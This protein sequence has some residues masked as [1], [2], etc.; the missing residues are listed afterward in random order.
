MTET[1]LRADLLGAQHELRR[2]GAGPVLVILAGPETVDRGDT[3]NE[4][5]AWMD[6]RWLKTHA[7]GEASDEERER[8]WFWRYWRALPPRG[9]VALYLSGWYGPPIQELAEERCGKA[10]FDHRMRRAAR[11][12]K[13][14]VDDGAVVVKIWLHVD[15][16]VQRER[17]LAFQAD[18][19]RRWRA[20]E[21]QW[22]RLRRHAAVVK[23]WKRA[24]RLTEAPGAPWLV[25][26]DSDATRRMERVATTVRDAIRRALNDTGGAPAAAPAPSGGV[27]AA[28]PVPSD[29]LPAAPAA[30]SGDVAA[31]TPPLATPAPAAP[32]PDHLSALDLTRTLP[33]KRA[34]V[35][36]ERQQ[37]R[38]YEAQ[39]LARERGLS[40]VAVFE[41]WDASG[42]GGAVRRCTAALDARYFRIVP[43]AAPTDEELAHHYL[44]RFW[45]HIGRAGHVTI[46]DRSWYGR[47]LVERVEQFA[48]P[49]EWQR[50][51]DEINDFEEQLIDHGTVLV[52]FWLHVS[53]EEQLERFRRRQETPHKQWKITGEDWRNREKWDAYAGAVN[54]MVERTSTRRAPW[55]L[56]E[57]NDKRYARVKVVKTLASAIRRALK[58]G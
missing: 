48:R 43:I 33:A 9:L 11:F 7:W 29:G 53:K 47:V 32:S 12:E 30:S 26:D 37:G 16:K 41:G 3:A 4:L 20:G 1:A 28:T 51:Y 54:E 49:D 18:P 42:K 40:T 13:A 55:T 23:V 46:F 52:K 39:H 10:A 44:W 22:R 50:A 45:R 58:R 35:E 17:L 27:A 8:P 25:I 19:L 31:S 34:L 2:Q 36:L 14:M 21:D 15:K 56:V 24:A 6:P 57:G 5:N 38:L